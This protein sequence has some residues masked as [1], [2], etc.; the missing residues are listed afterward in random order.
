M[1]AVG[2]ET[3]QKPGAS[4][5]AEQHP[6][7]VLQLLRIQAVQTLANGLIGG[8]SADLVQVPKVFRQPRLPIQVPLKSPQGWHLRREDRQ[9]RKQQIPH[10]IPYAVEVPDTL[11]RFRK[12]RFDP[13]PQCPHRKLL[14]SG[15]RELLCL[16][17][18][19]PK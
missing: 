16:R 2:F 9:T 7:A 3:L 8:Q 6:V 17:R 5:L 10:G 12:D 1:P 18:M 14:A 13:L 15:H 4:S 19:P 11:V